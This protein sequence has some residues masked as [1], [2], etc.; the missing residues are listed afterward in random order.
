MKTDDL[1]TALSTKDI[2]DVLPEV[3]DYDF[4]SYLT[5]LIQKSG[6]K[7]S[8]LFEKAQLER[9][10]GYQILKGRRVPSRNKVI[11]LALSMNLNLDETNRLLKLADHGTLYAN[12]KRDAVIIY[13]LV[14]HY[15]L[16]ETNEALAS[17]QYPI[18][19]E[20]RG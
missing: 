19:S 11:A 7:N 9:S 17:Y 5:Y 10:Y 15:S 8:E 18:L 1:V 12:V 6:I 16:I 14:R 4:L 2:D 20:E 3:A 13:C